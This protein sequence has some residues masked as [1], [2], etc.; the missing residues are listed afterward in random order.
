MTG[1]QSP[2]MDWSHS[3]IIK[4]GFLDYVQDRDP[5]EPL[6]P[7]LAPDQYG[8]RSSH[9]SRIAL[10]WLRSVVGITDS[11]YVFHPTRRALKTLLRAGCQRMSTIASPGI[12]MGRWGAATARPR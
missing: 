2:P 1:N 8:R 6:F 7:I 9:A 12:S 10:A 11:R 3:A 4:A 5:N